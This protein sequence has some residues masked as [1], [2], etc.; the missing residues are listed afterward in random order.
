[1]AWYNTQFVEYNING[2]EYYVKDQ[3]ASLYNQANDRMIG[4]GYD[5]TT[6]NG[7]YST[8]EIPKDRS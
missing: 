1:V 2:S 3:G 4:I 7:G 8:T 5:S 6:F